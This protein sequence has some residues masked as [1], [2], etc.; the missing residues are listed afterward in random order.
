MKPA[1][2]SMTL[3]FAAFAASTVTEQQLREA[4]SDSATWLTYGKNYLGWRYSELAEI[5]TRTISRLA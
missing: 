3:L 1:A 4:Q 5:N 2:I